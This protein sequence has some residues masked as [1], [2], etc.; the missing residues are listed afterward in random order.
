MLSRMKAAT[1]IKMMDRESDLLFQRTTALVER[2]SL[3]FAN[4]TLA[5]VLILV[6]DWTGVLSVLTHNTAC[7]VALYLL[8]SGQVVGVSLILL[9]LRP[10]SRAKVS[11]GTR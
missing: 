3:V 8:L 10:S 9:V 11:S 5:L 4:A 7:Q 6:L 1:R 2:L